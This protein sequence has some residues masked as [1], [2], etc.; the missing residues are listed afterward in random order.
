MN[1]WFECKVRYEK[2]DQKSGKNKKVT[3]PYLIDA[4]TFSE[5]E[6]RIYKTL[7]EMISG[8]FLVKSISKSNIT[9]VYPYEDGDRWF[10]CK[11][12]YIDVDP[13]SGKE[14][15]VNNYMLIT[16]D[17]ARTAYDRAQESLK[18]MIIPFELPSIVESPIIDVIPYTSASDEPNNS[19]PNSD[20]E[21]VI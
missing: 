20:F 16:A 10:K 14:K 8:E 19:D 2:I 3:E 21:S 6:E 15:K 12:S 18:E 17:N 9:E 13:E 5:A 4:I 1:S 11:L 7:E